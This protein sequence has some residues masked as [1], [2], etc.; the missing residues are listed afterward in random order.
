[1][2]VKGQLQVI[3]I[4]SKCAVD[5]TYEQVEYGNYTPSS[6]CDGDSTMKYLR[7][8]FHY[9]LPEHDV[10]LSGELCDSSYNVTCAGNF[11]E[12]SDGIGNYNYNGF[13][14]A[15]DIVDEMN[16]QLEN[17][18]K[19][20]R[21]VPG[22]TYYQDGNEAFIR[23]ILS[24]VYF[25]RNDYYYNHKYTLDNYHS[26]FNIE[27]NAVID[28]Y[29]TNAGE[30]SGVFFGELGKLNKYVAIN[31]YE[32]YIAYCGDWYLGSGAGT[33]I[34]EIGH[35]LGLDHS[36][37]SGD[38]VADTKPGFLYDKIEEDGDCVKD[39]AN[40][41]K[42]DPS[43]PGCPLKPCDDWSKV[44]N[45]FMDYNQWHYP[46]I[47][48]GQ[49]EVMKKNLLS[50]KGNSY[51]YSCNGCMPSQAFGYIEDSICWFSASIIYNGQASYNEDE[52][53]IEICPVTAE[54]DQSCG[55]G[56]YYSSGWITG[57]IGKINLRDYYN[58]FLPNQWYKLTLTVNNSNCPNSDSHT[59][60]FEVTECKCECA[61][62]LFEIVSITNP[63]SSLINIEYEVY[64]ETS[65]E[66][67]LY[68]MQSGTLETIHN[69]GIK[70]PGTYTYQY[71]GA[72]TLSTGLYYILGYDSQGHL[73]SKLAIK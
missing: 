35:A 49:E 22:Y 37:E 67:K 72:S 16:N 15:E 3:P 39:R 26:I 33:A 9:I 10:Q 4:K 2:H 57:S 13:M 50:P 24:G 23:F 52:Y 30:W 70:T 12:T 64:E 58:N 42:Y 17:A 40:C 65:I 51:I 32:T 46:A 21:E 11:T 38:N 28:V 60:Y 19:Q 47:T 41:W 48:P 73:Q 45:N 29:L 68:D 6:F 56:N 18:Q 25:H 43:I 54:G 34:H 61:N 7:L 1:M 14:L 5:S 55:N 8:A 44:S 31:L 66:F 59:I 27:G 69:T 20:W 36:W 62:T 71:T 63:F 53:L